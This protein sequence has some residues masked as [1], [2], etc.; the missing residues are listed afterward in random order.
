MVWLL[1]LIS[2]HEHRFLSALPRLPFF[3]IFLHLHTPIGLFYRWIRPRILFSLGFHWSPYQ[4]CSVL[5]IVAEGVC[6][7]FPHFTLH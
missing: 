4:F 2:T 5:N 1:G 3:Y 6:T 7:D